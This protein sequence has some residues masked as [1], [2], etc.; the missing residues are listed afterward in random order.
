MI[1]AGN[2]NLNANDKNIRHGRNFSLGHAQTSPFSVISE[3]ITTKEALKHGFIR[4][5]SN[6]LIRF[7]NDKHRLMAVQMFTP[8]ITEH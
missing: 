6:S 2:P 7:P 8:P 3:D 1:S 5:F 4:F